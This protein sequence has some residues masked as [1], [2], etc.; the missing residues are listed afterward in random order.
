MQIFDPKFHNNKA[1]YIGQCL[2][3]TLVM[4]GVFYVLDAVANAAVIAAL[5][6]TAFI[7][8]TMPHARVA[9]PRYLLGGYSTGIICGVFC[10]W[11]RTL[12]VVKD[13]PINENTLVIALSTLAMGLT[14]FT[15]V[16]ANLEHPPAAGLALGLVL[17]QCSGTAILI[18]I[19]G[20]IVVTLLKTL[21]KPLMIN[22][23]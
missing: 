17:N 11:L 3:T 4:L 14:I 7:S 1:R 16:I 20:I 5:G 15:M 2:L 8:F 18:V 22:L 23:L 9:H 12:D 10:N 21:L 6:A 13:L 19:L